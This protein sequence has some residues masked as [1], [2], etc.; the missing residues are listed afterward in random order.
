[1]TGNIFKSIAGKILNF[2]RPSSTFIFSLFFIVVLMFMFVPIDAVQAQ[3]GAVPNVEYNGT[4]INPATGALNNNSS[5]IPQ[6]GTNPNCSLYS[7]SSWGNCILAYVSQT[8][9]EIA[10]WVLMVSAKLFNELIDMTLNIKDFITKVPIVN[11]GWTTFRDFTNIFFIFIILYIAINTIIGNEGYGIKKLLGKTIVTA[12]LINFSLFFTQ[13]IIDTSNIVA[14]QFY[15]KI[16]ENIKIGESANSTSNSTET[17]D[18]GISAAFVKAVGLQNIY[19][20]NGSTASAAAAADTNYLMASNGNH[21]YNI[22][23]VSLGGTIFILITS[24]VLVAGAFMLLARTLTLIFLMILSPLAFMGGILPSTQGYVK[25]WWD[26]LIKNALFAPA[27][28]ALL[29]LVASMVLKNTGSS[30]NPTNANF[31]DML[32]GTNG[33]DWIGVITTYVILN[34]LMVGCILLASK[35]GAGGSSMAMKWGKNIGNSVTGSVIGGTK[36]VT[37]RTLGAGVGAGAW[38]GRKVIGGTADKWAEKMKSTSF[39]GSAVGKRTMGALR[40]V[41]NASFDPR[42]VSNVGKTLGLGTGSVGG[43][44]GSLDAAVKKKVEYGESLKGDGKKAYAENQ[45]RKTL[46]NAVTRG[47]A[48]RIAGATVMVKSIEDDIK[49]NYTE[50]ISDLSTLINTYENTPEFKTYERLQ[51]QV[52]N[53]RMAATDPAYT[54]AITA[55]STGPLISY[56]DENNKDASASAYDIGG[57]LRDVRAKLTEKK[58]GV[59]ASKKAPKEVVKKSGLK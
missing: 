35:I 19:T 55:L 48:G 15:A 3:V 41:A 51:K 20:S 32:L 56:K 49:E 18:G 46:F 38:A 25:Q 42:N 36:F 14:L 23:I 1:M 43:Y 8:I 57:K 2:N 28:M 16:T 26:T 31:V 45:S 59:E 33:V 37:G 52:D 10:A 44:R 53:G 12:I 6:D 39:A 22:I 24:F 29:Y 30:L 7:P 40:G 4:T 21:W 34:A 50:R 54:N 11:L 17:N 47:R 27:Y 5:P 9:L 13:I 58:K